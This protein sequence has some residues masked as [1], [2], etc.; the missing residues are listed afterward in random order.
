MLENRAQLPNSRQNGKN[1][2]NKLPQ[3]FSNNNLFRNRNPGQ[4]DGYR[5]DDQRP[6]KQQPIRSD[7]ASL[8][9][10]GS[11]QRQKSVANNRDDDVIVSGSQSRQP[12]NRPEEKMAPRPAVAS[13][14]RTQDHHRQTIDGSRLSQAGMG[15]GVKQEHMTSQAKKH[16][17]QDNTDRVQ[18]NQPLQGHV[19]RGPKVPKQQVGGQGLSRV[20]PDPVY[21]PPNSDP[22]PPRQKPAKQE[23]GGRSG[24]DNYHNWGGQRLRG[25]GHDNDR[26]QPSK[27]DPSPVRP[28]P[29]PYR[30]NPVLQPSNPPSNPNR[31]QVA[32]HRNAPPPARP[33]I[34]DDP[35]MKS[36]DP[37]PPQTYSRSQGTSSDNTGNRF[38]QPDH[39]DLQNGALHSGR[40]EY[41]NPLSNTHGDYR[42]GAKKGPSR[43]ESDLPQ[44]APIP[45][46]DS[47]HQVPS[48]TFS[49]QHGA[50]W[51]TESGG[52]FGGDTYDAHYNT[53]NKKLNNNNNNNNNNNRN[54]PSSNYNYGHYNYDSSRGN[55]RVNSN[56]SPR[57]RTSYNNWNPSEN[58]YDNYYNLGGDNTYANPNDYNDYNDYHENKGISNTIEILLLYHLC[59]HSTQ[60][61]PLHEELVSLTSSPSSTVIYFEFFWL[62][63]LWSVVCE[64]NHKLQTY[65]IKCCNIKISFYLKMF[66]LYIVQ[67][68]F[69]SN[70]WWNEMPLY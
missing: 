12:V 23:H 37:I 16:G 57:Y 66:T 33:V 10:V 7:Y 24:E 59:S 11:Q 40:G 50:R 30:N 9:N 64:Y 19:N 70:F 38:R 67:I 43:H 1:I 61:H 21:Q 42:V 51:P 13:A 2:N 41:S 47:D 55:G 25:Q 56:P 35:P 4:V 29:A 14:A 26:P 46:L 39:S 3:T 27:P 22:Q 20:R 28:D 48:R 34:K 44:K 63:L 15:A 60:N 54:K 45:D 68:S 5:P 49:N 52:R 36:R 69:I 65:I 8:Q 31:H 32:P 58:S 6:F 62:I 53:N 17:T 18:N